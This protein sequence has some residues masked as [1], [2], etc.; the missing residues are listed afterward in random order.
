M[1][2]QVGN[3]ISSS[4]QSFFAIGYSWLIQQT[5]SNSLLR[6]FSHEILLASLFCAR[7]LLLP[8]VTA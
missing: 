5:L 4:M 2:K 7:G 8:G 6:S 1:P 3:H